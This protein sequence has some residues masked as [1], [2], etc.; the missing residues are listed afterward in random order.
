ANKP[1]RW[2]YLND[3][4][5]ADLVN[6]FSALIWLRRQHPNVFERGQLSANWNSMT[7][8]LMLSSGDSTALIVGNFNMTQA[9]VSVAA[10]DGVWY[11]YFR[12][13]SIVI[14]GGSLQGTYAPGEYHVYTNF[15]TIS[16]PAT[17]IGHKEWVVQ[18]N[19]SELFPNP[20][21]GELY[22]RIYSEGPVRDMHIQL[23]NITGQLVKEV[24][25][26]SAERGWT[27]LELGEKLG[28]EE[29]REGIYLYRLQGGENAGSGRLLIQR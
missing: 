29:L 3:Q 2:D 18:K 20:A 21:S 12:G 25:L 26:G 8:H 1:V 16:A 27:T 6:E 11:D 17:G 23:Y 28:I 13:D 4:D 7:K 5:R 15:K 10:D 9:P 14:S 24:S 22:L 19:R